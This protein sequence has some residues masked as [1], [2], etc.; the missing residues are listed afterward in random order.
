M[1][2]MVLKNSSR[3][4]LRHQDHKKSVSSGLGTKTAVTRTTRLTKVYKVLQPIFMKQ[5]SGICN[6]EMLT[7]CANYKAGIVCQAIDIAM[8]LCCTTVLLK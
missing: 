7:H 5:C 2:W 4:K 6:G 1:K 8:F 3:S